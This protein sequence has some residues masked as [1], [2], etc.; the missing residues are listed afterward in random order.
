MK[1]ITLYSAMVLLVL[2][3][4][5]QT[6]FN[7]SK[8]QSESIDSEIRKLRSVENQRLHSES[9]K[10][11]NRTFHAEF[12]SPERKAINQSHGGRQSVIQNEYNDAGI[13]SGNRG[14]SN[15]RVVN[16]ASGRRENYRTQPGGIAVNSSHLPR[17][18]ENEF[19]NSNNFRRREMRIHR[20]YHFPEPVEV[21]RVRYVY[22]EP[23]R[24]EI[25]WSRQL[26]KEF[27]TI[28]PFYRNHEYLYGSR[29]I[30]VPAFNAECHLGR[31]RSVYGIVYEVYYDPE[32]DLVYLYFGAPYPHHDFSA[33]IPG[34]LAER[35][36]S[37]PER[38]F[39]GQH[40]M[41]TG[42]VALYD[43]KPEI[44]LIRSNQIV[45]Y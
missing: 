35:F 4:I 9:P 24:F 20:H 12:S 28:Y 45:R 5:S 25:Y 19:S 14:N 6:G 15:G 1:T 41:V 34:R 23:I 43:G 39:G 7:Y 10:R 42:I 40:V 31:L 38:Y 26:H 36:S 8:N 44:E 13:S 29:I 11:A 32:T 21:R 37:R 30:A 22:R 2:P 16:H 3:A 17:H 33:V 18:S 27:M